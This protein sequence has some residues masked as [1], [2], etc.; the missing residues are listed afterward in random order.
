MFEKISIATI[1]WNFM[2]YF[3]PATL[4]CLSQSRTVI[5]HV[6]CQFIFEFS[7]CKG[8]VSV[9]FVDIGGMLTITA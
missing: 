7:E 6:I 2:N 1:G 4:F 3:T 9:G 5:S 8:V